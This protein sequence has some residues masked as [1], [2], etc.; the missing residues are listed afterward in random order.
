[1]ELLVVGLGNPGRK[2]DNTRHN[3]GFIALDELARR[4]SG[5]RYQTKWQA[6]TA[7]ARVGSCKVYLVKPQT[8]MNLSGVAVN[9]FVNFFKLKPEQVVVIHD[10]LD[11]QPGR[12]KLVK[13]GGAGG[14]KGIKSISEHLGSREFFRLKLGIGRPGKGE[15]SVEYPVDKYVLGT[16]GSLE[17][18]V[19]ESRFDPIDDGIQLICEGDAPKAMTTL[20]R[21]K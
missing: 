19:L 9:S 8:F 17:R 20:N 10:D 15:V 1:M 14:H 13:G 5:D 4:W 18:E 16:L 21:L 3:V 6:E 2:Y 12:V 11:M 7:T